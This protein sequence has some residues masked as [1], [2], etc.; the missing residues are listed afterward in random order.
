MVER[1]T[2]HDSGNG[3]VVLR[4][5]VQGRRQPVTVVGHAASAS[6]GEGITAIGSWPISSPLPRR[7]AQHC[8]YAEF[9]PD[10]ALAELRRANR[11][12]SRR[13]GQGDLAAERPDRS[14]AAGSEVDHLGAGAG[15]APGLTKAGRLPR[16]NG[17][18]RVTAGAFM[19]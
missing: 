19:V 7:N 11:G 17:P 13:V 8:G 3:F 15:T 9:Y 1:V 16:P 4:V 6:P 18:R 10:L 12:A 2:F 5:S 14:A